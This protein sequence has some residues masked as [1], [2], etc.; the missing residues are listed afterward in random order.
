MR[1]PHGL[2]CRQPKRSRKERQKKRKAAGPG[3]EPRATY[4]ARRAREEAT[5]GVADTPG[6]SY[7]R[8][9]RGRLLVL[10]GA[11][12]RLLL[13]VAISFVL[14]TR[15]VASSHGVPPSGFRSG[16]RHTPAA[17]SQCTRPPPRPT[18]SKAALWT[19]G[20]PG[21]SRPFPAKRHAWSACAPIRLAP[22]PTQ[23]SI[24][25]PT[26]WPWTAPALGT[27]SAIATCGRTRFQVQLDE[28]LAWVLKGPCSQEPGHHLRPARR[29]DTKLVRP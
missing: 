19:S 9:R 21:S 11:G 12:A 3:A 16:A 6:R 14:R 27:V 26:A 20:T 25:G 22:V 15:R 23:Y 24:A 18:S 10:V 17:R 1:P 5:V 13:R 7:A 4:G 2:H 29:A 28:G 8:R